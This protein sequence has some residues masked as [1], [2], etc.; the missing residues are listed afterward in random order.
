MGDAARPCQD[1]GKTDTYGVW[2]YVCS[3]ENQRLHLMCAAPKTNAVNPDSDT[4]RQKP[5]LCLA[6]SIQLTADIGWRRQLY[7]YGM[8]DTDAGGEKTC[9]QLCSS[10]Y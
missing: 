6:K 7:V 9:A 5:A 8:T 1:T 4:F 3:V 2:R 10:Q